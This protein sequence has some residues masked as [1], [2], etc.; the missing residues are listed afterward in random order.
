M[1]RV[2]GPARAVIA[3]RGRWRDRAFSARSATVLIETRTGAQAPILVY[4]CTLR[5]S[6]GSLHS[7]FGYHKP[8]HGKTVPHR[9]TVGTL[10]LGACQGRKGHQNRACPLLPAHRRSRPP[11]P[12][13]VPA[14]M[15]SKQPL[16]RQD[17]HL[18][19]AALLLGAC[20]LP[21]TMQ[22]SQRQPEKQGA[23]REAHLTAAVHAR[24][25]P[26]APRCPR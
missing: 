13:R 3:T 10:G 9:H 8:H 18:P 6:H 23:G 21:S 14:W 22:S 4:S 15:T 1:R 2:R 24:V 26:S 5:T 11:L 19:A 16:I 12:F 25:T 7:L 20:D 17:R